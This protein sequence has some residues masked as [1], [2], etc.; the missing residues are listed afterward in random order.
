MSYWVYENWT[1][2]KAIIHRDSCAYC[3]N[4][5][6]IHGVSSGANDEWHGPYEL[7][8]DAEAKANA[9]GRTEVRGCKSCA[10]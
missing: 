8:D 6:G 1:H 10:A 2:D 7:R 5:R 9:T 3:N 4:G